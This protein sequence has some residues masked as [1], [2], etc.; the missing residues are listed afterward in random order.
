MM[1]H[2]VWRFQKVQN[3]QPEENMPLKEALIPAGSS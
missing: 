3:I 2:M 1:G